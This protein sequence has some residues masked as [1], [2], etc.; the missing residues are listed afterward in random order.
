MNKQ[1]SAYVARPISGKTY[2][3]ISTWY[4]E[5][6]GELKSAGYTVFH[7]MIAKDAMRPEKEFKAH[8]VEGKPKATNHAIYERDKWMCSRQ[9]VLFVDFTDSEY[10]SIGS[11]MELAISS[12][13]G[14]HTVA[15]IPKG[16]VHQHAFILEA[17]DIVFETKD[18]AMTYLKQLIAD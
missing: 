18:E 6:V 12:Y 9:D 14:V 5:T 15:V 13:V 17:A 10:T 8:G 2:E 16:N 11:C 4:M 7:P 3:E 1:L